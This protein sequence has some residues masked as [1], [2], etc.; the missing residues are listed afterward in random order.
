MIETTIIF[1]WPGCYGDLNVTFA[2]NISTGKYIQR[3]DLLDSIHHNGT[4]V[5][6]PDY[7]FILENRNLNAF[8][9][10]SWQVCWEWDAGDFTESEIDTFIELSES[11]YATTVKDF[12]ANKVTKT[13][14]DADFYLPDWTNP[15]Y[16]W[17]LASRKATITALSDNAELF[18]CSILNGQFEAY[19]KESITVEPGA[20]IQIN[21]AGTECFIAALGE[22]NNG[23]NVL[24]RFHVYNLT[25]ESKLLTNKGTKRVR[26]M[27]LY[28]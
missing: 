19:T 24:R 14:L 26:I 23:D 22:I 27:R 6:H 18:C 13:V 25:S 20:D 7:S 9:A 4:P 8:V 16:S 3:Q 1:D 21:R 11:P 17:V 10:G 28:K 2:Q 15:T 12:E 5:R